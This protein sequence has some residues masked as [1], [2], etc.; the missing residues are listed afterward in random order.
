M[1]IYSKLLLGVGSVV[2]VMALVMGAVVYQAAA[3]M[4]LKDYSAIASD[5]VEDWDAVQLNSMALVVST[6]DLAELRERWLA[7]VAEFEETLAVLYKDRRASA[8]KADIRTQIE[9]A[10]AV[11]A[12]TKQQINLADN[13]LQEFIDKVASEHPSLL[14]NGDGLM[15]EVYR[16]NREG[17]LDLNRMAYFLFFRNDQKT[18]LLSHE[19]FKVILQSLDENV[20]NIVASR[21]RLGFLLSAA[22]CA[23]AIAGA[24]IY[25]HFFARRISFRAQRIEEF[26][27]L[28]AN[29]DFSRKPPAL[30]SDE[31]GR[32]SAHLS[33]AIDSLGGFFRSVK[34]AV[35]NVTELKDA[36]SAGTSQ[37]ASSVN[38]ISSNIESITSRFVVLDSA[39]EQATTALVQIGQYLA[40]FKQETER[41]AESMETAGKE[42]SQTVQSVGKVSREL[43]ERSRMAAEFKRTVLDGGDRVQTTNEIIRAIARDIQGI[44]EVIDLIDQ[45]SE[46]TNIL[47]MNAA[48]ESAHAGAAGKG[49]AVVAEEIRKLAESTQD[50]AQRIGAALKAITDK[51]R[52]ALDS[53][54]TTA[55]AFEAINEDVVGFVDSLEEIARK[56]ETVDADTVNVARAI[57]ESIHSSLRVSEGTAEMYE[58]HHAVQDAME[59][60]KAISDEA[61]SGIR[62]IDTGSREILD[63]VVRVN[64]LSAKSRERVAEL[65]A[66]MAGFKI[67]G[68]CLDEE[69]GVAVK[70]P[71]RTFKDG[72]TGPGTEGTALSAGPVDARARLLDEGAE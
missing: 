13:S 36:L 26:M 58:R 56:A 43:M 25:M 52:T 60:I 61:V 69:R 71:P 55:R 51:T 6:D 2:L 10:G 70:V 32:L 28:V 37:S 5:L 59:N 24:L 48:I 67:A 18:I 35:D 11:W 34:D 39:I 40:D 4:D 3:V 21:I 1:K 27:G 20:A 46:Q 45:I 53:S 41:Q 63:S 22:L 72:G 7:S 33:V 68:D 64:D 8:L 14:S 19:S 57:D 66:A 50:N 62:E 31:I 49:F 38:E 29:R 15:T 30:G 17:I 47:S 42:L 12:L 65:E 44:M 54:E 9:S 16:L 23:A